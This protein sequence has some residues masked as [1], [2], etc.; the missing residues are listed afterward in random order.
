MLAQRRR[1]VNLPALRINQYNVTVLPDDSSNVS[2]LQAQVRNLER[3][4]RARMSELEAADRHITRLEEKLFQLKQVSRELKQLKQEKQALRKSPERRIGQ[5]LLAPYRL[6]QKLIQALRRRGDSGERITRNAE[7]TK[8][9]RWFEKH[10]ATPEQLE[11]MRSESRKFSTQPLI[12]V[13][14]PVFNTPTAWLKEALESVVNQAY[15]NWELI[16]VDDASTDPALHEYLASLDHGDS[17]IQVFKLESNRGISAAL[18]YAVEQARGEWVGF[19]DHDDVLEPDAL[20]Q[21]TS[22]LQQFPNADL[23]YSDE[24]KLSEG[25]LER[26]FFKPDWS[27]DFFLSE[28][29]LRHFIALR[30]DLIRSVGGFRSEFDGAQ[31]YDLLLRVTEG[32]DRIHHVPRVLYHWRRSASSSAIDVRQKPGQLDA[33]HRAVEG[34]LQRKDINGRVAMDWPTHTFWVQRDLAKPQK[35]SI[36]IPLHDGSEL[37]ERCL[38]SIGRTTYPDSPSQDR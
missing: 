20:F 36:I 38:A 14:T 16:L 18:N 32:T 35:I 26:P 37:L 1:R 33:A 30:R 3:T 23:I 28:N 2:R 34:H 4:L 22:L 5:V 7:V 24:D 13:V 21:T 19:L 17:R 8:Y 15:E 25:G 6:P 10:R 12:S 27:P 31:D 11:E 9:Q 29:Y